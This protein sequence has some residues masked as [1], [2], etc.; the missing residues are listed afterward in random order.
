MTDRY[1][2]VKAVLPVPLPPITRIEAERAAYR[3][4]MTFAPENKRYRYIP[5]TV[6]RVWINAKPHTYHAR[7][8]WARLIHDVSHDIFDAHYPHKRAHDPLH[9]HYE[10]EV[11]KH[12]VAKGWL[13]GTLAP[14]PPKIRI[15]VKLTSSDK[16]VKTDA[17]IKRWE[18]KAKRAA[19]ALRKLRRR[20][21]ALARHAAA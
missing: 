19:T 10:T 21:A 20:R 12:V 5:V 2:P 18:T 1:D 15:K 17:D 11:A 4:F 16:L 3:L 8:G 6:R 13:E 7:S 9:V 14:P